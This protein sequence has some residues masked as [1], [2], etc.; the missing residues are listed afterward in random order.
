M[1]KLTLLVFL[2]SITLTGITQP[3]PD[4]QFQTLIQ[5]VNSQGETPTQTRLNFYT[6]K[7]NNF[8]Y[9]NSW[10]GD[11][12][13]SI[14]EI[15]VMPPND[16]SDW[17]YFVS[18]RTKNCSTPFYLSYDIGDSNLGELFVIEPKGF[19]KEFS[20]FI[21]KEKLKYKN[22]T[23]KRQYLDNKTNE[24]FK[25]SYPMLASFI[26]DSLSQGVID[27]TNNTIEGLKKIYS[28]ILQPDEIAK[29][30]K[31]AIIYDYTYLTNPN[32]GIN[33]IEDKA[34][35]EIY[36]KLEKDEN[37][38]VNEFYK[39]FR[40]YYKRYEAEYYNTF[41][42][43]MNNALKGNSE[44]AMQN[45]C[46]KVNN[47][48][49]SKLET[50]ET[51]LRNDPK[52]L[53]QKLSTANEEQKAFYKKFLD[54]QDQSNFIDRFDL[55]FPETTTIEVDFKNMIMYATNLNYFYL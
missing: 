51:I 12:V 22:E 21:A 31:S 35:I 26:K 40:D 7:M 39:W 10:K 52:Y 8:F 17:Y 1:K 48:I 16:P 37:Y 33:N 13:I 4:Q 34:K 47:L 25:V 19:P 42:D 27:T 45:Y 11:Q 18:V 32:S 36:Y 29:I 54:P 6:D 5:R 55:L 23:E 44:Q 24:I 30:A 43:I 20:D 49:R 53:N 15:R 2:T 9:S 46:I 41:Y 14:K 50:L 3:Q 28:N 38:N